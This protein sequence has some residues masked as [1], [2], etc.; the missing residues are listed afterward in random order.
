MV[1]NVDKKTFQMDFGLL[2]NTL[3]LV[4][5]ESNER[6]PEI[7]YKPPLGNISKAHLVL[8]WRYNLSNQISIYIM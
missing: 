1:Q 5:T 4:L 7:E 8:E 6:I 3:A 2:T